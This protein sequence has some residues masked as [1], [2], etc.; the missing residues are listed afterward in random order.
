MPAGM[1]TYD[2]AGRMDDLDDLIAAVASLNAKT[3]RP[4]NRTTPFLSDVKIFSPQG[5]FYSS[6]Q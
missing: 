6:Y 2:V 3:G 5:L 1:W 4:E